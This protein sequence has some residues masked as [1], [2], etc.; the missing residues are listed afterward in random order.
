MVMQE[1]RA[2]K[3]QLATAVTKATELEQRVASV[4]HEVCVCLCLDFF[5]VS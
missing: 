1:S 2:L 4:Q 3:V 5:R